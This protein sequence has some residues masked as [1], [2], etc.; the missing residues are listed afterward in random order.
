MCPAVLDVPRVCGAAVGQAGRGARGAVE[1]AGLRV[2]LARAKGATL[3]R[4]CARSPLWWGA[5]RGHA[6]MG[7]AT[8]SCLRRCGLPSQPS[9]E[10]NSLRHRWVSHPRNRS[11]CCRSPPGAAPARV[12]CRSVEDRRAGRCGQGD[13][14]ARG[15]G[16]PGAH[17]EAMPSASVVR[18]LMCW[19]R[20]PPWRTRSAAAQWSRSPAA[21]KTLIGPAHRSIIEASATPRRRRWRP[22]AMPRRTPN[23]RG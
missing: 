19:R 11:A 14:V 8:A 16:V 10:G 7:D 3:R 4:C 6:A 22:S 18:S 9:G 2:G 23:R 5:G 20:W 13:E 15:G 1:R 17:G 12:V 21:K